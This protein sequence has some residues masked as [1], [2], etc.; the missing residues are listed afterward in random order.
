[1]LW[2]L[3][4]NGVGG[5]GIDGYCWRYLWLQV[6]GLYGSGVNRRQCFGDNGAHMNVEH[7]EGFKEE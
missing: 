6:R 4:V 1:M 3:L 2:L 5:D 7:N